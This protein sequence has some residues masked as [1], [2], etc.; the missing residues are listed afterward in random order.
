MSQGYFKPVESGSLEFGV[1]ESPL[2]KMLSLS[3]LQIE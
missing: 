2:G 3:T 1:L